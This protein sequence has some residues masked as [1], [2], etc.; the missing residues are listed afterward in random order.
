MNASKTL[1]ESFRDIGKKYGYDS[2][3]AEFCGFKEFK[4][5][6]TRSCGWAEFCVSDYVNNAPYEVMAGLAETIFLRISKRTGKGYPQEMLN[7]ITSDDFV[8]E[9]QPVYMSR[10]RNLTRSAVG[11]HADLNES[12]ERLIDAGLAE[13]N[14]Q[15]AISWTKRPNIRRVGTCSVLMKVI[16]ISS[17]LDD[18]SVPAFVYDYVLYHELIHSA[19]GFD[20]F[21]QRHGNDFRVLEHLHP[22]HREAEEWLGKM[23]LHI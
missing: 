8:R 19:K 23:R 14:S 10:S 22:M 5:K 16:S 9:K 12:Y 7:W 21:G 13:Y 15:L 2:V 18:P 3:A 17:A 6:W 20:P 11:E 4:V 1:S